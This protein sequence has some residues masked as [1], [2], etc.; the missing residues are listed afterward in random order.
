M[1]PYPAQLPTV[2][3]PIR[4]DLDAADRIVKRLKDEP[5]PTAR[6]ELAMELIRVRS[7]IVDTEER[8][9]YVAIDGLRPE[10][11]ARGRQA[12]MRLREAMVPVDRRTRHV[13]A[14]DVH[15]SDAE[16]FEQ[17]LAALAATVNEVSD[18][19]S[20]EL[21]P[22]LASLGPAESAALVDQVQH[23]RKHASEHPV[24]A[25]RVARTLHKVGAMM[26]HFPDVADRHE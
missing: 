13:A 2:L 19:E 17:E 1:T 21:Y 18:W 15:Q 25:G 26:D 8:S 24:A 7:L 9:V 11:A 6:A 12:A 5:D 10:V 4:N 23:A 22:V 16:G 20:S 3:E 14:M